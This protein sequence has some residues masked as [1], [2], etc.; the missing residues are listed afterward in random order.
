MEYFTFVLPLLS[1]LVQSALSGPVSAHIKHSPDEFDGSGGYTEQDA[2]NLM[3]HT[4]HYKSEE[5][6]IE[7]GIDPAQFYFS[8]YWNSDVLNYVTNTPEFNDKAHHFQ[9]LLEKYSKFA[10]EYFYGH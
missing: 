9:K 10:D 5:V 1:A 2:I 4:T 3:I 8:E 7:S 6:F